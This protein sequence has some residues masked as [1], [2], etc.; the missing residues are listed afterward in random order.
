MAAAVDDLSDGRLTLGL[1]A[2]WQEREHAN[3]GW[4][5]LDIPGRFR[6]FEEGLQV[7]IHLL[8]SDTPVDFQGDYYHLHDALLL[9][10]PARPGGPRI[11]VGGNGAHRTLP[12]AARYAQEWNAVYLTAEQHG[13]LNDQLD[14]LLQQAGRQKSDV[15]RS[16]MVGCVFGQDEA[17]LKQK[18]D[19]RTGGKRDV[20]QLRQHGVVAGT[21]PE[22]VEQLGR[23]AEAGLQR[24]MLQ[25]LDLEDLDG[26]EGLA[27][28]VIPVFP[29]Q[30]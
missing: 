27:R 7:I 15:R 29:S 18:V 16:M 4:D 13:P 22:V 30:G 5:L 12:L 2:G 1:G 23:L 8:N 6:R 26:L 28:A 25:W 24:V 17:D 21:A 10:R 3:F 19:R 11:L 14:A 20:L 9:P